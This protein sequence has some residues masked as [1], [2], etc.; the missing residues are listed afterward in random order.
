MPVVWPSALH[1]T[2]S[3]AIPVT[4]AVPPLALLQMTQPANAFQPV[5]QASTKTLFTANAFSTVLNPLPPPT[6]LTIFL[7]L[8]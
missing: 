8:A 6:T 7:S 2:I 3:K 5:L 4:L 1:L